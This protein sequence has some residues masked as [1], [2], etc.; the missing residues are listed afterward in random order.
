MQ[1]ACSILHLSSS[2]HSDLYVCRRDG[3]SQILTAKP[4][5][6]EKDCIPAHRISRPLRDIDFGPTTA[7]VFGHEKNGISP[8]MSKLCDGDF[9]IPMLGLTE[10]FNVS[11]AA[12]ICIHWGEARCVISAEHKLRINVF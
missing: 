4:P 6:F 7:L 12:A 10:S 3:I 1:P 8:L 9:Y 11:V 5:A 2:G